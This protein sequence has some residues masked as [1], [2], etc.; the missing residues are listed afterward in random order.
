MLFSSESMINLSPLPSPSLAST[1]KRIAS[2][3][4]VKEYDCL[5]KTFP[6]FDTGLCIPGVSTNTI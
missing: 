3:S 6:S 1:T 4:F 5:F 2:T